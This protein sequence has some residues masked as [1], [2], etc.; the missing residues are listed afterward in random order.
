MEKETDKIIANFSAVA[1]NK[2]AK[3]FLIRAV[4]D[5][6]EEI[7]YASNKEYVAQFLNFNLNKLE[8]VEVRKVE[9][10]YIPRRIMV[11]ENCS[12]VEVVRTSDFKYE[13]YDEPA[14]TAKDEYNYEI[15]PYDFVR[16][17]G[18]A[19]EFEIQCINRGRLFLLG[20]DGREVETT[21]DKVYK[22][23]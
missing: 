17:S 9:V 14:D 10:A 7:I 4:S 18:C 15:Q 2:N 11:Y 8:K 21:P 16:L 13:L 19:E 6:F 3:V 22:L 12:K 23:L 20:N 5:K 1:G